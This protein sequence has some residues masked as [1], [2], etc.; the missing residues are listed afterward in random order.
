MLTR[1]PPSVME[2]Q[3]TPLAYAVAFTTVAPDDGGALAVRQQREAAEVLASYDID[4]SGL[5]TRDERPHAH[6]PRGRDGKKAKEQ[7]PTHR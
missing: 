4:G 6:G 5:L 7:Q 3:P 1:W 2:K